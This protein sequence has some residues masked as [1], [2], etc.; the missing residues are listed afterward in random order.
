MKIFYLDDLS[1]LFLSLITVISHSVNRKLTMLL[2]ISPITEK[3]FG[4]PTC[5]HCEHCNPR[6][7]I[8]ELNVLFAYGCIAQGILAKIF[9]REEFLTTFGSTFS[10]F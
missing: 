2:R 5:K 1:N 6:F 8:Y 3:Y 4:I 9:L 7:F 10:K